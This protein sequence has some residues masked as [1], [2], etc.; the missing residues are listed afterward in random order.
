MEVTMKEER[1]NDLKKEISVLVKTSAL[2]CQYYLEEED[3]KW[4]VML[5]DNSGQLMLKSR[6]LKG[7]SKYNGEKF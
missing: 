6:E 4:L 7:Y 2:F 1:L 5:A 3:E